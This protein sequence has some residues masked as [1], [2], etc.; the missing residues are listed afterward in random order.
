MQSPEL[1]C[2]IALMV[3]ES[4]VHL[5]VE[6]GVIAKHKAIEAIEGVAELASEMAANGSTSAG[7]KRSAAAGQEHE[8]GDNAGSGRSPLV[9]KI[10][11][12][13]SLSDYYVRVLE[14]R[15]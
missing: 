2:E 10:F 4:L 1:Q 6:Q 14:R 11:H 8:M 3:C 9:I 13:T 7:K 15:C 5:L 12:F